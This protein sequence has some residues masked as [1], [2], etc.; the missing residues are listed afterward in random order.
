MEEVAGGIKEIVAATTLAAMTM[1]GN[2]VSAFTMARAMAEETTEHIEEA[3]EQE[4]YGTEFD[5]EMADT[6]DPEAE[7]I[8][9]EPVEALEGPVEEGTFELGGEEDVVA[10]DTEDVEAIELVTEEQAPADL[11]F[12]IGAQKV[13]KLDALAMACGIE[14]KVTEVGATNDDDVVNFV[15][16][17]DEDGDLAI[18]FTRSFDAMEL[19]FITEGDIQT[20]TL[21]GA[22]IAEEAEITEDEGA[23]ITGEAVE[24]DAAAITDESGEAEEP[25]DRT[26]LLADMIDT[27]VEAHRDEGIYAALDSTFSTLAENMD[28][29][30]N[31]ETGEIEIGSG[32][33]ASMAF[34][35]LESRF[36]IEPDLLMGAIG[37]AAFRADERG[38]LQ[39]LSADPALVSMAAREASA[40]SGS[41]TGIA[42]S[43]RLKA[44]WALFRLFARPSCPLSRR[45]LTSSPPVSAV[46]AW[47][48]R[49]NSIKSAN[50]LK[51]WKR[52]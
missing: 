25:V 39:A 20:V 14:D 48:F 11:T 7:S 34:D 5:G 1:T 23:E 4:A 24:A 43:L 35:V 44:R 15:V 28:A 27:A 21:T 46:A 9:A 18:E 12:E 29:L 38:D 6:I 51:S 8:E 3:P 30:A 2:T 17:T 10:E 26:Q 22:V 52:T 45:S 42:R 40:R 33:I 36:D 50:S 19:A 32:D 49:V 16:F 41:R 37:A 47:I 13:F 31:P